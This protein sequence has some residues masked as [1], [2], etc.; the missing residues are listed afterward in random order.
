[1]ART[2]FYKRGLGALMATAIVAA[3][4]A[5]QPAFFSPPAQAHQEVHGLADM[6]AK[7]KP[8]VV[9]VLTKGQRSASAVP[10][11]PQIPE[12]PFK[13]FMERFFQGRP[14]GPQPDQPGP[15]I[16]GL[17]SGFIVAE[18]GIVVTNRH[19]VATA[20][21]ILVVLDNGQELP[22]KIVGV[23]DKT[24]LAVLR[25]EPEARLPVLNWGDSDA[26]RIGDPIV[27]IGNPFGL[28]GTVTSG[29]VSARGRN[30]Q[31]GPYDDFI[32]IDAAINRGNSGGPLFNHDGDVIGVNTAIFSPNGGNVGLGFAIPSNQARSIVAELLEKGVVERGYIGVSVQPV[33]PEIADSLGLDGVRGALIANVQP[34]GA[35]AR[36]GLRQG[37]VI[38]H[39]GGERIEE[40]RDISRAVADTDPGMER[41]ITVWRNGAETT[42]DIVTGRM[43]RDM[44]VAAADPSKQSIEGDSGEVASLGLALAE[45][46]ERT[47]ARFS[48]PAETRGLVVTAIDAKKPAAAKGIAVGDVILAVGQDQVVSVGEVRDAVEA[49]KSQNRKYALLL[50]L[51]QGRQSFVAV[52]LAVA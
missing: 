39:F 7:V 27:A 19:V 20:D 44:R 43:E 4:L 10:Q 26:V 31:S 50:V 51:H 22:A 34:D 21:E 48:I 38:L 15:V 46:T 33:T 14:G 30:I 32:Q 29:I 41:K 23:D 13:D 8:G 28:G 9:T 37:D 11:M 17:G 2:T 12:G 36:A 18:D 47:R 5:L 42:F 25:V 3:P 24:D 16:R 6:V 40:P 52:P 1:M 35:A 45:L 49:L